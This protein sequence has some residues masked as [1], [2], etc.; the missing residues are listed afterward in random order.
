[1][2]FHGWRDRVRGGKS[3]QKSSR[4]V[5][6]PASEGPTTCCQTGKTLETVW[7]KGKGILFNNH[8]IWNTG[9]FLPQSPYLL[10]YPKKNNPAT[11]C[12]ARPVLGYTQNSFSHL[13]ELSLG[14]YRQLQHAAGHGLL[15]VYF[16][17]FV[18]WPKS[19]SGH[20]AP[21]LASSCQST[22]CSP[23]PA[24]AAVLLVR[25]AHTVL[26]PVTSAAMASCAGEGHGVCA[27]PHS[28]QSSPSQASF[29][30]ALSV[31]CLLCSWPGR[32]WSAPRGDLGTF[33]VHTVLRPTGPGT[34]APGSWPDH[35]GEEK[36]QEQGISV[37][38]PF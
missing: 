9:R 38:S 31:Q 22:I 19:L 6:E 20:T 12:Q 28:H 26:T 11:L 1:M 27:Q 21:S 35:R 8:T 29:S 13:K 36:I 15:Q 32:P 5:T 14:K 2:A 17:V 7:W 3:K 33:Q 25:Q 4:Y 30:P 16:G 18:L 10:K 37:L 23:S 24:G 34:Q